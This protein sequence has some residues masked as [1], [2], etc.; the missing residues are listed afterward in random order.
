[1]PLMLE[2]EKDGM[3]MNLLTI[4]EMSKSYSEKI[5]INKVSLG[6]SDGDKI[7]LIGVNGTG[8]STFLKIIAGFEVPD[9]GRILKGNKVNIEYLSQN[10]KFDPEA[11]VLEQIFKSETDVMKVIR[12][13][14]VVMEKMEENPEDES[15][16]NALMN[17][18]TKMDACNGWEVQNEAKIILTKLGI[19]DFKQRIGNLSGG[20]RK[21]VDRKSVV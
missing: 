18:N 16:Q 19:T 13:Y 10:P 6:I 12:E 21:R 14:E 20:Q 5:L 8:K 2:Q 11:T 4:E 7:G 17:L 3:Y 15:V 9:A 1:M